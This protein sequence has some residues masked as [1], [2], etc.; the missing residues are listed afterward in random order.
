MAECFEETGNSD[1]D[2]DRAI[3]KCSFQREQ[4]DIFKHNFREAFDENAEEATEF[5]TISA[6]M[7][8]DV[9][10]MARKLQKAKISLASMEGN[11]PLQPIIHKITEIHDQLLQLSKTNAEYS[12]NNV[13]LPDFNKGDIDLLF[14]ES[15]SLKSSKNSTLF[16]DCGVKGGGSLEWLRKF[17]QR[18]IEKITELM[19]AADLLLNEVDEIKRI[20]KTV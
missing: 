11:S 9:I 12:T 3:D 15:D 19:G 4:F 14:G 13:Q 2:A 16:E 10:N 17:N 1:S 7:K 8:R 5:L 6:E 18:L 20:S